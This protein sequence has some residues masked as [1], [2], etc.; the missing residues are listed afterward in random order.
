MR[1]LNN[2][3]ISTFLATYT[4]ILTFKLNV[5]LLS[6]KSESKQLRNLHISH[7]TSIY[8]IHFGQFEIE[9]TLLFAAIN[10]FFGNFKGLN[11]VLG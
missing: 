8:F 1:P 3:L 2:T 10:F 4:S 5:M 11:A 6:Q 7:Q 9:N